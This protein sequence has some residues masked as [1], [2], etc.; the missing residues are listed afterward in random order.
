MPYILLLLISFLF[1]GCTQTPKPLT[2]K[3]PN[4]CDVYAMKQGKCIKEKRLSSALEA[5][6]VIFLGDH[7]DAKVLHKK[8]AQLLSQIQKDGY[9]IH[10]ANEWFTPKDNG[11]LYQYTHHKIDDNNFSK[12]VD[13]NKTIGYEYESFAPLYRAVRDGGGNLYGINLTTDERYNISDDNVSAM[14]ADA[15][16]FYYSLDTNVS[17]HR[18]LLDPFLQHCHAPKEGERKE[19]CIERIYKVQVAWDA[20][21]GLEVAKLAKKVLWTPKDK[22]VVFIGAMHVEYGL[23]ATMRFARHSNR[24]FVT[25]SAMQKPQTE[26]DHAMADF[27]L[28]YK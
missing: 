8:Y 24:S 19:A 3:L 1:L 16:A 27:V 28:F 4:N 2:H 15:L 6:D 25:L 10:L 17:A 23:G 13:F 11:L 22:L 21:M 20:K 14:R 7:H 9:R 12:M 18:Q 26:L 5:Y